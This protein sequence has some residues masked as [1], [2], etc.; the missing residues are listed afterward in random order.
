[1]FPR[2]SHDS[3]LVLL[4]EEDWRTRRFIATE[5]KYALQARVIELSSACEAPAPLRALDRSIDLLIVD[6]A[7]YDLARELAAGNP[8]CKVLLISSATCPPRGLPA[9]WQFLSIPFTTAALLEFAGAAESL[10]AAHG[11]S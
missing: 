11:Q 3:P 4:I 8:G 6:A 1:M 2:T 10:C 7:E 5:L 9:A